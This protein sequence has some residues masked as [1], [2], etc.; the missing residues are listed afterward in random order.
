MSMIKCGCQLVYLSKAV[1]KRQGTAAASAG[2]SLPKE[3]FLTYILR[4]T[5]S[6]LPSSTKVW[7]SLDPFRSAHGRAPPVALH[8]YEERGVCIKN[9]IVL[10]FAHAGKMEIAR[11]WTSWCLVESLHRPND[12]TRLDTLQAKTGSG[13]DTFSDQSSIGYR[14]VPQ[15][16]EP[17]GRPPPRCGGLNSA[18]GH[19]IWCHCHLS[20]IRVSHDHWT[21]RTQCLLKTSSGTH[22]PHDLFLS[23][24]LG[25][26]AELMGRQKK[27][28]ET[29][30]PSCLP[31]C[32]GFS[33][34]TETCPPTP[35]VLCTQA[36]AA[37]A[38]SPHAIP[39]HP[40]APG[41]FCTHTEVRTPQFSQK[42][43]KCPFLFL[44][45]DTRL[46]SPPIL[47]FTGILA[48]LPLPRALS[49]TG[50]NPFRQGTQLKG[51]HIPSAHYTSG[52][53]VPSPPTTHS[54]ASRSQSHPAA[55][56]AS[57]LRLRAKLALPPNH[58]ASLPLPP[59]N[60]ARPHFNTLPGFH[61]PFYRKLDFS[62]LD[63]QTR[64]LGTT[65]PT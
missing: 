3:A 15:V 38:S 24:S 22:Q 18:H 54:Y 7:T 65:L 52:F 25:K 43:C 61:L 5:T 59:H 62:I 37:H 23:L 45:T 1:K 48:L 21:T 28:R 64:I 8:R 39:I 55:L 17:G 41:D 34:S 4:Y 57:V 26:G 9:P 31:A 51:A 40:V 14:V 56:C 11:D 49:F 58:N 20:S 2:R 19:P 60:L 12:S 27:T 63:F 29:S 16:W 10:V 33:G 50:S 36:A 30:E 32:L 46:S 6:P 47:L 42:R 35:L 53:T 44:P 13:T